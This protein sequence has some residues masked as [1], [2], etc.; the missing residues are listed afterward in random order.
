M[1]FVSVSLAIYLVSSINTSINE[2]TRIE[3]D[4]AKIINQLKMI[5]EAEIAYMGVNGHYTSDWN[6][7]LSFIDFGSFYL[8]EK[9]E[10]VKILAYGAEEVTINIDTLGTIPVMD[11]LFTKDKWPKFDL[12]LLP[13]VPESNPP[14]KFNIWTDKILK[15]GLYVN[16]IEVVNPKPINPARDEKSEYSTRK[17]L[18]FGSRI[19]ITTAGNWE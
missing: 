10:T 16:A 8:T 1:F 5:R 13:Y 3:K 11:S 19:S 14:V 18:R 12:A 7:L 9:T 17:P 2:A 15:A 6:K 4:E